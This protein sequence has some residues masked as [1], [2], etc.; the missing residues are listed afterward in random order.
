MGRLKSAVLGV[1][2]VTLLGIALPTLAQEAAQQSNP[3]PS[4]TSKTK[5][6]IWK[7]VA[8]GVWEA[9]VPHFTDDPNESFKP[10]FAVLRLTEDTYAEFQKDHVAFLNKYHIFGRDVKKQ[11]DCTELK[12][13][14][15]K[16]A[17]A[18]YYLSVPHWPTS[19]AYCMAYPGWSEPVK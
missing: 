11:D 10:E 6:G 1:T 2:S 5:R 17:T 12:A 4:T 14:H 16:K 13:K 15:E 19:T 8:E 7:Q 3:A 18:F 9:K